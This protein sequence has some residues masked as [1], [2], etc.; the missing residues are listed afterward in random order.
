MKK[1]TII[2]GYIASHDK[3]AYYGYIEINPQGYIQKV[4]PGKSKVQPD[5]TFSKDNLIFAGFG[6]LHI[7]AR[8]DDT[9]K[10]NYKEDYM[11]ASAAACNG[12]VV[13][14]LAMPNT[15]NPVTTKKDF[16]WHRDRVSTL[17]SRCECDIEVFNYLGIDKGTKPIGK[18]GDYFYKLYFGKSVGDLTVKYADE[19]DEIL[20][21]YVGHYISFHVEYEPIVEASSKGKT[22]SDR[23]P[24]EC[25]NEGLRL[26]LPLIKKY[27]IHAKLCH[28]SVGGKS[29][30]MI[31]E[32]RELGCDITLEVSPLHL[33]FDTSLTDN[34]PSLWTKIQMNPAIQNASHRAQ[35]IKG[36]KN[37]FIQY[38]ATDHAPHTIEEK[39]SAFAKYKSEFPE[40]SNFDIAQQISKRNYQEYLDVCC[41]NGH[42]GAPWLDTYGLVCVWLMKN[43]RFT[44]QDIARVASY[45]PGMFINRFIKN[46]YPKDK[47]KHSLKFG[48]IK[49]SYAGSLT[50]LNL[51]KPVTLTREMLKTKVVWSPLEN[52][53]FSGSVQAVFHLG[54][55][56]K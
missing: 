21:K 23:R 11:T 7:H 40:L 31:D 19:L 38:L 39:F 12:G 34:D 33:M 8:E 14:I 26:L 28:W 13:H 27:K 25:V 50:I 35:L 10:Q 16:L 55:K 42:S 53:E 30:E 32:Y 22:H 1:S 45:N 15:P 47:A 48:E 2:E 37:G 18:P 24:V 5:F 43:H 52:M 49:K 6:D 51:K 41:E 20:A 44:S 54:K 46:Q 4:S 17:Q 29:F 9:G 3:P 56:I 36:L